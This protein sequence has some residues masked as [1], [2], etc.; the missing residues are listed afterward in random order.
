MFWRRRARDDDPEPIEVERLLP[1]QIYRVGDILE[2]FINVGPDR[3]SDRL[4]RD[5]PIRIAGTPDPHEDDWTEIDPRAAL[6]IAP[7]LHEPDRRRYQHRVRRPLRARVGPYQVQAMAHLISG[8][9]LDPYIV[10]TGRTFLAVTQASVTS[11]LEPALEA[12]HPV[13]LLNVGITDHPLSL[14]VSE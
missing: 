14:D 11:E 9:R 4:N 6:L 13:L 10:R 12:R 5:D 3:L 8:I 1:M 2:V 7:P